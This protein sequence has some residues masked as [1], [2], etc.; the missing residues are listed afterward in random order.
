MKGVY[1]GRKKL[2]IDK[3]GDNGEAAHVIYVHNA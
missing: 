3:N 2:E 1:V